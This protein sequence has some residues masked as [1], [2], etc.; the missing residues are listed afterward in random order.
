MF[1]TRGAK[2][3]EVDPEIFFPDNFQPPFEVSTILKVCSNCPVYV[4]CREYSLKH[5]LHGWWAGMT[6]NERK[7]IQKERGIKPISLKIPNSIEDLD[8]ITDQSRR[9]S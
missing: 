1:D 3:A 8:V 7:Q 2:C 5:D 9:A 4:A 6:R